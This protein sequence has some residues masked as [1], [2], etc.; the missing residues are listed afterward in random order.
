MFAL[1]AVTLV[2]WREILCEVRGREALPPALGYC[3]LTIFL[4]SLALGPPMRNAEV[5]SG[6]L[7]ASVALATAILA[8]RSSARDESEDSL[9]ALLLLPL[10]RWLIFA[11]KFLASWWA[12]F[13]LS[14]FASLVA[15]V[16]L[17][18]PALSRPAS[19]LLIPL[20]ASAGMASLSV[21]LSAVLFRSRGRELLMPLLLLPLLLPLLLA[22]VR[23]SATGGAEGLGFLLCLDALFLALGLATYER[24]VEE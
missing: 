22:A 2:A 10:D 4:F 21:T 14:L 23:A 3:A 5:G 1:K 19:L 24:L 13:L 16:L 18:L 8:S 11:G 6:I 7:W 15:S 20:L 17:S 12:L 9:H